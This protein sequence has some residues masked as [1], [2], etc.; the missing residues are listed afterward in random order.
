M[1]SYRLYY[2]RGVL[3]IAPYE[4]LQSGIFKWN[5][6]KNIYEKE[7]HVLQVPTYLFAEAQQEALKRMKSSETLLPSLSGLPLPF[8]EENGDDIPP[9]LIPTPKLPPVKQGFRISLNRL[10]K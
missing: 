3:L 6:I 4:R 5:E 7:V 2:Y 10:F 1:C 8:S 9:E